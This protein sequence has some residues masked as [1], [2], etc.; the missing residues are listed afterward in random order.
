MH[1]VF[2]SNFKIIIDK[3][4]DY[5]EKELDYLYEKCKE[6]HTDWQIFV[7]I[8]YSGEGM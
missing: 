3:S 2:A 8:Y 6:H 5:I 7:A 1:T 4:K